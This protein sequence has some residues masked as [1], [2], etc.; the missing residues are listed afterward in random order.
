MRRKTETGS[1]LAGRTTDLPPLTSLSRFCG[2]GA[3]MPVAM[4][5]SMLKSL[6]S[7][8]S[9]GVVDFT[10]RDDCGIYEWP[11]RGYL[12]FTMDIITPV[13]NDPYTFGQIAAANALSDIYAMGGKPMMAL[14]FLAFPV[15]VIDPSAASEIQRGGSD[16]LSR[17]NCPLV[18]GHS[19]D[20]RELKYGLAV[21]GKVRKRDL[22][23]NSSAR[24][25][26]LLVL[27][28]PLGNGAVVKAIKDRIWN[29]EKFWHCRSWMTR[30]NDYGLAL[31]RRLRA[32]ACVDVTGYGLAGH[33]LWM[34]EASGVSLEINASNLPILEGV[35]DLFRAGVIP[36]AAKNNRDYL[37]PRLHGLEHLPEDLRW[38][39]FD[40]QTSGGLLLTVPPD[41]IRI[42]KRVRKENGVPAIIGRVLDAASKG[43]RILVSP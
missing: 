16:V 35:L 23:L 5:E 6:P 40:P 30:L 25:G 37:E 7:A 12:L 31:G 28:K 9:P 41:S 33:A 19:L 17:A 38:I 3:K 34:A 1:E 27:T 29:E 18:G 24:P 22:L 42:L 26:D 11:G 10:T 21:V 36:R 15:G 32:H 13:A 43:P 2:C 8:L 20:D 39:L 14:S 4:L